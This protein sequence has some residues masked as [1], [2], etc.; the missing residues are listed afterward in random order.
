M[1]KVVHFHLP[2]D[3]MER[4]KKFYHEIFGW[5]LADTGMGKSYTL[6]TTVATD[7][8]GM[9]KEP[10]AINGAIYQREEPEESQLIIINVPYIA[11]YLKK[12]EF[13]GGRVMVPES[14]IGDFAVYAQIKDTEGNVIGLYQDI[15]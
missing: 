1:D 2:A 15:K 11:E 3:D 10:G 13:S 9:P 6:A 7:D 12:V 8:K 5:E 4:A 14:P